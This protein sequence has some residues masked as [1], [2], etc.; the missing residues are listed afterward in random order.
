MIPNNRINNGAMSIE[1]APGVGTAK[2]AS[3]ICLLAAIWLFVSP[4]VYG[5]FGNGNAWN[6]WIVGG[7]IF[8]FALIRISRPAYGR[9]FSWINLVLGIWV[10]FSPWIYGYVGNTGRFINS[11]C[12]GVVVFLF[13]IVSA[14]MISD[15]PPAASTTNTTTQV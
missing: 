6:S 5:A 2:A 3:V 9:I 15:V 1:R 10:F 12:V 14:R 7:F 11:L 13:S 4:W 8:L